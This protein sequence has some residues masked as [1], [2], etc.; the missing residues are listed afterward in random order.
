MNDR[1]S[2]SDFD[3][4]GVINPFDIGKLS[5]RSG[6]SISCWVFEDDME[7]KH[8]AWHS[9]TVRIPDNTSRNAVSISNIC[10]SLVDV[11]RDDDDDDRDDESWWSFVD[12][13]GGELGGRI[14]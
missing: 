14:S 11:K 8:W 12:I 5:T 13:G 10:C 3:A 6:A 1:C 4:G 9:S 7:R 2:S